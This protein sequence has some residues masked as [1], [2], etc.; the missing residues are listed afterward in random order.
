MKLN[1]LTSLRFFAALGVFLHHFHFY[2][3]TTSPQLHAVYRAFFEGFAGVTFF[4]VLSGFIISY[5]YHA[6]AAKRP[7]ST[8]EFLFNRFARLYPVHL[9]TLGIAI[10]AYVGLSNLSLIDGKTL[11]VNTL[12]MQAYI[13]DALYYFSFNGVA[14]SISAELFFYLAFIFLLVKLRTRTLAVIAVAMAVLIGYLINSPVQYSPIYNWIFYINPGFRVID[15]IVGMLVF[16]LFI[17]GRFRV[18]P[19]QGT[20][21]EIGSLA[22]LAVFGYVGLNGVSMLWRFDLFYVL[23]MAL[24]VWVFAQGHGAISRLISNRLFVTLGEASFSLYMI[25]QIVIALAQRN[26]P[27]DINQPNQVYWFIG[28]TVLIGITCSVAM[29]FYFEKPI[30]DG[31]RRI[32]KAAAAKRMA[33]ATA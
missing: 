22:L 11:A 25:H 27:V 4:Y 26:M 2:E 24:V 33:E 18:E 21:A 32:W 3:H 13:P 19:S 20:A 7:Y 14:W 30:N 28:S 29:Y 12:L 31:L 10:A 23:P 6:Q 1:A 9:L 17:T 8:G 5:S 16:R 15:F